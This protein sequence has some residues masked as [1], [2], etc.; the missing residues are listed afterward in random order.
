[1]RAMEFCGLEKIVA[2]IVGRFILR[3][4]V[5]PLRG[6]RHAMLP[7][8]YPPAHLPIVCARAFCVDMSPLSA[9]LRPDR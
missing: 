2:A 7:K 4:N 6:T 1:M 8:N 9:M 5:H 3:S